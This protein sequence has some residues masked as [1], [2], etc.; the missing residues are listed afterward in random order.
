MEQPTMQELRFA[1]DSAVF[2]EARCSSDSRRKAIAALKKMRAEKST[3]VGG[4]ELKLRVEIDNYIREWP[5][6][7]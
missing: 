1:L 6:F 2:A 4:E 5:L 3:W 7:P